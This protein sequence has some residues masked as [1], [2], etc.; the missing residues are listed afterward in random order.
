V[1]KQ[2]KIL[3]LSLTVA[4]FFCSSAWGDTKS[5]LWDKSGYAPNMQSK[6]GFFFTVDG[7]T[8]FMESYGD[9]Y[10]NAY[11]GNYCVAAQLLPNSKYK[12]GVNYD[13]IKFSRKDYLK[14]SAKALYDQG[15]TKK[16]SKCNTIGGLF[17]EIGEVVNK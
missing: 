7:N 15:V 16:P 17:L 6:Q 11:A 5:D 1:K 10:E 12:L 14:A 13:H 8:Y 2:N 4:A 3:L 9:S